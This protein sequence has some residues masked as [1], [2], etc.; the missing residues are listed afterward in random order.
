MLLLDEVFAVGDEEFQRK[1][2]GKIA[3]FKRRGGTIVF[4]SHDAVSVERLC[5]RAILLQDGEVSFD[6]PVHARRRERCRPDQASQ[7]SA[8]VLE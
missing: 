2:F 5:E 3:E 1:C 8:F 4:V 7:Y 6:G